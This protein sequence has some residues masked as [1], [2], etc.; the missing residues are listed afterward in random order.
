MHGNT[1]QCNNYYVTGLAHYFCNV[2]LTNAGEPH[3]ISEADARKVIEDCFRTLFYRDTGM[4][5][6]L[7]ICKITSAGITVEEP[8]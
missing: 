8:Y 5:D 7:Q 4:S 6:R 1:I 2:L 3:T